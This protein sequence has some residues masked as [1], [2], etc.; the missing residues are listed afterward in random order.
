MNKQLTGTIIFWLGA[1]LPLAGIFVIH[2]IIDSAVFFFWA[3][4]SYALVYRPLLN[5]GRLLSLDVIEKK[6]AWRVFIPFYHTRYMKEIWFGK[7]N[8]E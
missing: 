5:I 7:V 1:A 2:S 4:L 3:L 8:N 6:D